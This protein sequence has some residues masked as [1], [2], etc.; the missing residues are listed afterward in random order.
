MFFAQKIA[1]YAGIMLN[2]FVNQNYV[3]IRTYIRTVRVWLKSTNES[4]IIAH[5]R[6]YIAIACS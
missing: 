6:T 1:Y 5:I 4:D 3:G 2:D